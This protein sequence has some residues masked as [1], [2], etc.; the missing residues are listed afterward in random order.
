[1]EQEFRYKGDVHTVKITTENEDQSKAESFSAAIGE[2][3]YGF[4]VAR[5]STNCF[6]IAF[7]DINR[8]VYAAEND[9]EIFI[10]LNGRVVQLAKAGNDIKKF[11][12][13]GVEFGAKDEIATPM[14]GKVVKILVNEGDTI[15]TGQSLVIVES[16]KM[17]NEIKSPTNG[18]VKSI[19]FSD[20]DLVGPNQLIIKLDPE[21]DERILR[22]E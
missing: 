4:D 20:G 18:T 3:K 19:H 2:N 9:E 10:H 7:K 22:N 16:M 13:D 14:P 15:E 17:E 12:S 6:S 21:E 1:M 5:I 8:T 11:S